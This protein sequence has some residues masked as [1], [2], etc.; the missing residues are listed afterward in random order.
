MS[1]AQRYDFDRLLIG[2]R[3]SAPATSERL[4]IR[5]PA[6]GELVGTAP[7]ATPSDVDAA[8]AAARLAF[9]DGP[10]PRMTTAERIAALRPIRERLEAA[11]AEL[12]VLATR[13]NGVPI[14][15]QPTMSAVAVFDW[16]LAEAARH[17]DSEQRTGAFGTRGTIYREPVGVIAGIVP[18][19]GPLLQAVGKL[20]PALVTGCTAVLKPAP[21]TP[22]TSLF[23][24]NLFA[25][26]G[27]PE[28]VVSI[29]PG[30]RETGR[31]LVSHPGVDGVAFTGS[32]AAGRIIAEEC[33]R[34]LKRVTL[35]L[36]GKSAAVVLDDADPA[37]TATL[38]ALGC[39]VYSGQACAALTRALIPAARYDEFA[40]AIDAAVAGLPVGDP[41]DP[42][43]VIGPL[44]AERQLTRVL[45][46]V[47]SGIAAGAKP[48]RGGGRVKDRPDGFFV[49]P[50]ILTGVDNAMRVAQEEIFGPVL[51][52][53]PYETEAD[54]IRL[55]NDTPYG[56]SGA[57]FSGDDERATRV[58]RALRTGSVGINA[59]AG[60]VGL[61]FGG[62]KCSGIGREFS[63]ETFDH[64]T[65]LKTVARLDT[66]SF[67]LMSV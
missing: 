52:L 26:A 53:I 14:S 60:D 33:G 15:V 27:L 48:L 3:W 40:A 28:G 50:T 8:V 63:A 6:T 41:L 31:H 4:E 35:E 30:D 51:C 10:W 19:N 12:D 58:A 65:E 22:L 61:P 47:D 9:D 45:D 38:I 43:T 66:A 23:L 59:L 20:A 18:W 67:G 37:Q 1:D 29:L 36:G 5:S 44:V 17:A 34:A 62:Y 7:H 24:A 32:T 46:Y 57:V 21:E 11:V 25:D 2:S 13:E 39:M 49:E 42:A 54:A 64:F 55:A 56:L 16:Y